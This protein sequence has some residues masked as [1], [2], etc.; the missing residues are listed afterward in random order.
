MIRTAAARTESPHD[1][2]P[3]GT[4]NGFVAPAGLHTLQPNA[5]AMVSDPMAVLLAA[6]AVRP[7]IDTGTR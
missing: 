3:V 1:A 6:S 4:C 2:R 5:A 7:V